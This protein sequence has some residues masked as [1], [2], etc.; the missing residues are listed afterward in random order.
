MNVF[1]ERH[2]LQEHPKAHQLVGV[3]PPEIAA[4]KQGVD[5]KSQGDEHR[6]ERDGNQDVEELRH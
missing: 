2:E 4:A 5:A 1:S 3:G 6:Q